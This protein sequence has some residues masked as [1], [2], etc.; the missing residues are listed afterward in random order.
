MRLDM[1]DRQLIDRYQRDLPVSERP[2]EDMARELGLTEA[3]VIERLSTLQEQ[4][5]LSRVGPVF[6]HSQAGASL[7][8]AVA[9]PDEQMDLVAARINRAPG[10][11]HNYAREHTYN[12]WFVMTAPN[13]DILE[14]RLDELEHQ[15]KLPMLRLPMVEGYHIDLGFDIDWEALP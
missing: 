9:A 5:V 2:Y 12:L 10:V 11:N 6:E 15:L 4:Q 14:E 13:D 7:L 8:A 3:E 1:A